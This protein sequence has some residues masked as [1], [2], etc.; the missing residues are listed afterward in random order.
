MIGPTEFICM[1]FDDL[2]VSGTKHRELFSPEVWQRGLRR[3]ESCFTPS[4][5]QAM[6]SFHQVFER[7]LADL[8]KIGWWEWENNPHWK[9]VADA[10]RTA[11]AEF[12]R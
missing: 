10:A 11:L 9:I 4:E 1:W 8:L 5:L 7:E 2:Y 12:E 6:A 3:F